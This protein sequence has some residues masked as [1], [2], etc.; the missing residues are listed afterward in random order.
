MLKICL[1]EVRTEKEISVRELARKSGVA[2]SHIQR[3]ESGE[4][5]PG[6]LTLVKL[7]KALDVTIDSLVKYRD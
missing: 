6:V 1:A 4:S 5:N 2:R 7:A 3:I